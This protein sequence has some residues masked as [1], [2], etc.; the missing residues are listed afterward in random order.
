[1]N[2]D[3]LRLACQPMREGQANPD[4]MVASLL[5]IF[6]FSF[7]VDAEGRLAALG[8][9]FSGR[10]PKLLKRPFCDAFALPNSS[11]GD[12]RLW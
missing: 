5:R 6:P 10:H 4:D 1:M 9:Y 8:A 3:Q 2:C 12:D 11:T 7:L